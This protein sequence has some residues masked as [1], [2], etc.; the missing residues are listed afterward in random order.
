MLPD[1]YE[2]SKVLKENCL[3][4]ESRRENNVLLF[5]VALQICAKTLVYTE[6]QHCNCIPHY[7]IQIC[8]M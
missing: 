4:T 2:L 8:N 6:I 3:T 7:W 5:L 1:K